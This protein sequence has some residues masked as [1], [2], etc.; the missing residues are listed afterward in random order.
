MYAYAPGH[1]QAVAAALEAAG[2]K[3]YVLTIPE[4]PG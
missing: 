1:E 2:G 4:G 3:A